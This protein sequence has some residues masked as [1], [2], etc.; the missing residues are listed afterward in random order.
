M[1]ARLE[2]R[3]CQILGFDPFTFLAINQNNAA[4]LS[5]TLLLRVHIILLLYVVNSGRG[6]GA[7]CM[8]ATTTHHHQRATQLL[9][10][11]NGVVEHW[12]GRSGCW[13]RTN[14]NIQTE[15]SYIDTSIRVDGGSISFQRSTDC[16]EDREEEEEVVPQIRCCKKKVTRSLIRRLFPWQRR[17]PRMLASEDIPCPTQQCA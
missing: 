14:V 13:A 16:Q 5:Y 9:P 1:P 12:A 11:N 10:A 17:G 3:N 2:L 8:T 7:M 6:C 4:K 15:I